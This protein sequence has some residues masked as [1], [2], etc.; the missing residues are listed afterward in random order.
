MVGAV[1][2]ACLVSFSI[3]LV[4]GWEKSSLMFSPVFSQV[5]NLPSGQ[6]VYRI[7]LCITT[8]FPVF[9]FLSFLTSL[10]TVTPQLSMYT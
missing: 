9:L 7:G 5:A 4:W 1:Y 3:E 6:Y 2:G 8:S 10:T